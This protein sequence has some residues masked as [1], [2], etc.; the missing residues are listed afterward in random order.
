MSILAQIAITVLKENRIMQKNV[1]S[2]LAN[3]AILLSDVIGPSQ[4]TEGEIIYAGTEEVSWS[5]RELRH[6]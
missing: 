4:A 6:N 3:N 5:V 2:K 1:Y